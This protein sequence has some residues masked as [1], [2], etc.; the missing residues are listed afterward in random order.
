MSWRSRISA[1]GL[2]LAALY[3][4]PSIASVIGSI[5]TGNPETHYI[6]LQLPIALQAAGLVQLGLADELGGISW[7]GAYALLWL[8]VALLLYFLGALLGRKFTPL[9][10]RIT[11][12]GPA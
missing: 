12:K 1:S 10:K 8:P 7:V 11:G 2:F 4:V 6:L 3:V 9:L 5:R